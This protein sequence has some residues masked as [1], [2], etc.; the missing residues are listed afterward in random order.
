M[1]MRMMII[2]IQYSIRMTNNTNNINNKGLEAKTFKYLGLWKVNIYRISN[3]RKI[4]KGIH[5]EIKK[6][7]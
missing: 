5:T 3:E 1:K 7:T 4:K 2:L 6:D